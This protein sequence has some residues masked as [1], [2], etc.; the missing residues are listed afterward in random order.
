MVG[1][2]ADSFVNSAA[3]TTNYGGEMRIRADA[4]PR[5]VSYVRFD[6]SAVTG[7]LA[8]ATLRLYV[9]EATAGTIEVRR[10]A[11]NTWGE[12]SITHANAPPLGDESVTHG[13]TDG[14]RWL[15]IDVT[16]L[17]GSGGGKV[18]LAVTTTSDEEKTFR[19]REDLKAYPRLELEPAP[20]P[21]PS[22]DPVIAAAGDLACDPASPSYNSGFGTSSKCRQLY[23]S[24]LIVG[25][26]FD[27]V[28]PL[29]D[30]QYTTGS[31]TQFQTAF[32]PSWG[33]FKQIQ[34]P[35]PGNHEYRTSGAS[36]YFDYFNG[37]GAL[38]G[39][40]GE[41]G[42]GY[43]SWDAGQWHM[44]ALNSSCS[45]VGGCG[46]GS[47]QEQWLR[48][49]LAANPAQCTLAYWHHPRFTSAMG[50]H[51][52]GA[53][54]ALF[55]ALYEAGADVLLTGHSHMYQRFAAQNPAGQPDPAAGI[56]QFVVGTGGEVLHPL[57][58]YAAP[59]TGVWRNDTFGV[60]KLTL[61][62]NGY[63]WRFVP[64]A[65]KTFTDSGTDVCDGARTD[66]AAPTTPSNLSATA[67][68][69]NT[70]SLTWWPARDDEG[71]SEYRVFRDGTQI[72]TSDT[73][74]FVDTSAPAGATSGYTVRA[75][76][77]AGKVSSASSVASASTPSG[78]SLTF[79]PVDDAE[80]RQDEPDRRLGD[81]P[82]L[83]VDASPQRHSL[84][85]FTV[86][87]LD[88]RVPIG[89][90]LRLYGLERGPVG[91]QAFRVGDESWDEDTVTWA[92]APPADPLAL[93]AV[94]DGWV[95]EGSWYDIPLTG[96][97]TGD[98]TYSVRLTTSSSDD[99]F[100]ASKDGPAQIA[101]RLIV[102]AA[103]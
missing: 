95:R 61:R 9:L 100:Y 28:L 63:D 32:E 18:S 14:P 27:A 21:P 85:K 45:A 40:A 7:P 13:P 52:E 15:A 16:R 84:L 53:T 24:D 81:E 66:V 41:R 2:E 30:N 70:V 89:A 73:P 36:G 47:P 25:G 35:V 54:S 82:S 80:V 67:D 98:G 86:S 103:G 1:S 48:A 68:G 6:A 72:G 11:D 51:D 39:P 64:E 22:G 92:N 17:V 96:L 60:L 33:R 38:L 19:P 37:V 10:V 75:V 57:G 8:R 93:G 69:A 42:K 34:H 44:V 99:V 77:P 59:N 49:D 62:S 29:G 46:P 56:R 74:T 101:P 78:A 71:V 87:G 5:K 4:T 20:P 88:G 3:P 50:S 12:R 26:G 102:S 58:G 91:G 90:K 79:E 83:R 97:V 31:L 23:T 65:G 43:Y 76:D 55:Q 94:A